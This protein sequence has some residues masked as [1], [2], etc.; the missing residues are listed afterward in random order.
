MILSCRLPTTL[1]E[2]TTLPCHLFFVRMATQRTLSM[3]FL[4]HHSGNAIV[5]Q[6]RPSWRMI[7]SF[8]LRQ[9]DFFFLSLSIVRAVPD[10]GWLQPPHLFILGAFAAVL[11]R[12][13][14]EGFHISVCIMRAVCVVLNYICAGM[15]GNV[16][17]PFKQSRHFLPCTYLGRIHYFEMK[18]AIQFAYPVFIQ[19]PVIL[20]LMSGGR[21]Q[22]PSHKVNGYIDWGY[23]EQ[24]LHT[25]TTNTNEEIPMFTQKQ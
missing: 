15:R 2:L 8:R 14:A 18:K 3:K 22:K 7:V 19:L 23:P 6:L 24:W 11:L 25:Y 9:H 1:H 5:I 12:Q 21:Q 10:G 16:C 20:Q 17:L 13:G 4:R